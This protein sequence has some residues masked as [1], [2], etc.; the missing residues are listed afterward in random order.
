VSD[1]ARLVRPFEATDESAVVA[2]WHR[3]GRAAYTFL[4]TWQTFTVENAQA[5]FR[6]VIRPKC[7]IWVGTLHQTVVAYLAV[8]GSYID[9]IYVD[10]IEWRKGWGARLVA[11]AK[12]LSPSGLELHTHQENHAAR[13][14]YEKQG[15]VA[16]R[17][18][19]SLPPESAPD[20]EYHWRPSNLGI[21][22]TAFGRG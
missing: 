3:S 7:D 4:P 8:N 6:N 21:Q 5:V 15:F 19:Q 2:V 17:F 11:L 20:V 1:S 9:R 22:P 16:V 18:G 14:L 12:E 10:P 13:A